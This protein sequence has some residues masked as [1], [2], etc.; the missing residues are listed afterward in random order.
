[1]MFIFRILV[2]WVLL[3]GTAFVRDIFNLPLHDGR[4]LMVD[5][6]ILMYCFCL[7]ILDQAS[8][9]QGTKS[10]GDAQYNKGQITRR[11]VLDQ[12]NSTFCTLIVNAII[13]RKNACCVFIYLCKNIAINRIALLW[14]VPGI[15][16]YASSKINESSNLIYFKQY[17]IFFALIQFILWAV[18]CGKSHL[19]F[20]AVLGGSV[21]FL[22]VQVLLFIL[23]VAYDGSYQ[24]LIQ[25][26]SFPIAMLI[27]AEICRE[28]RMYNMFKNFIG[29][30]IIS[31][32]ISSTKL[33]FLL[34]LLLL[35]ISY[36]S[37]RCAKF[38]RALGFTSIISHFFIICLPFI[39]PRIIEH[40]FDIGIEEIV[41]IEADRYFIDDNIGSLVSRIY[42]FVFITNHENFWAIF[43][44][45]EG[46][47]SDVVFWGYPVHNIYASVAYSH[48]ALVLLCLILYHL[49][50][51]QFLRNH[52]GLS[53]ILGFIII[54][55]NDIYPMLS[56]LFIPYILRNEKA[57]G[58]AKLLHERLRTR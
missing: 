58:P 38:P 54:Y 37:T 46:A 35:I 20:G 10:G 23:N 55:S 14:V 48:G 25:K 2:V 47:I 22:S 19:F 1:M 29:V 5:A 45:N 6:Y 44:N 50:I 52:I 57:V 27:L 51:Y 31:A 12:L 21:L 49:A 24:D 13:F 16:I 3:Q 8:K 43:G 53:I 4:S 11:G 18:R 28:A 56:L 39:V 40:F 34:A 41:E 9:Y 17:M 32:A 15:F 33:F 30:G 36:I 26:N 7:L 42:S